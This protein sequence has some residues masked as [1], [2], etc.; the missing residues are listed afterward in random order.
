M[1]LLSANT[2][3]IGDIAMEIDGGNSFHIAEGIVANVGNTICDGQVANIGCLEESISVNGLN[4]F[5]QRNASQCRTAA[6]SITPAAKDK[7][8]SEKVWESF[9][10]RKPMTAPIR[11][12]PPTPS[13]VKSTSFIS[14]SFR[15][16]ALNNIIAQIGV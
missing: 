7:T 3:Y 2:K 1:L 8:M 10:N 9:L 12:A 4:A 14:V 5:S 6:E 16:E 11:V 13:A 15:V